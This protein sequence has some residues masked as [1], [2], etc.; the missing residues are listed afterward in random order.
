L[1]DRFSALIANTVTA[2]V[3]LFQGA[4]QG[5]EHLAILQFNI[6]VEAFPSVKNTPNVGNPSLNFTSRGIMSPSR[7]R[8]LLI[9]RRNLMHT[10]DLTSSVAH[11]N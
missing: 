10:H 9:A 2:F 1:F 3:N 7:H 4:P 6:S 11:R 5:G 8:P